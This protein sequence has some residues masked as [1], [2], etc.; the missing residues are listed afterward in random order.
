M[1]FDAHVSRTIYPSTILRR[2]VDL[3]IRAQDGR[4]I[5]AEQVYRRAKFGRGDVAHRRIGGSL[6]GLS[7]RPVMEIPSRQMTKNC[8][9]TEALTPGHNKH[10]TN[11]DIGPDDWP[12][13]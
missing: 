11:F 12:A 13:V 1:T 3:G 7:L 8:S 9:K 4:Y 2:R 5:D 6:P 10:T